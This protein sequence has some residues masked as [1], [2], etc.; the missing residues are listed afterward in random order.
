MAFFKLKKRCTY[1]GSVLDEKG[2][3]PKK[4]CINYK[5]ASAE[6]ESSAKEG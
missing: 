3:C 2:N 6:E 4:E 5:G 1:C